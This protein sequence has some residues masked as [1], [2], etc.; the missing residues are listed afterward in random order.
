MAAGSFASENRTRLL[1][2]SIVLAA[3]V[4]AVL[5][6]VSGRGGNV[7]S[8]IESS[9]RA[10]RLTAI[11]KLRHRH[12]DD[13]RQLLHRLTKDADLGVASTAV[14]ALAEDKDKANLEFLTRL[15]GDESRR[16][17]VCATAAE[18]YGKFRG[19]GADHTVL[20]GLLSAHKDHRVRAGAA[21]GLFHL[22]KREAIA[23]VVNALED[24]HPRVRREAIR[25]FYNQTTSRFGYDPD[26]PP[27]KQREVIDKIRDLLRRAGLT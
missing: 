24:P 17:E 10:D 25:A 6:Y 16:P 13:S 1:I 3:V 22:R 11:D 8:L 7:E 9:N 4:G 12:N 19:H 23:A 15:L 5:W 2:G 21:R 26:V 14:K 27:G 20:T 18:V